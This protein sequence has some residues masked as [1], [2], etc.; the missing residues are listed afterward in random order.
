MVLDPACGVKPSLV[1]ILSFS[2]KMESGSKGIKRQ[3][4]GLVMKKNMSK[5]LETKSFPSF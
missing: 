5:L 2:F 3:I 4:V 1:R